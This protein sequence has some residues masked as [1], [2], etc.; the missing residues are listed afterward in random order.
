MKYQRFGKSDMDVSVI[1]LGNWASG[2][3]RWGKVEE[4]DAIRA[5]RLAVDLG[6]NFFDTAK[7]YGWG[8]SEQV[9]G[10]SLEGIRHKVHVTTKMGR[11]PR[12]DGQPGIGP[13]DLSP[14]TYQKSIEESLRNLR[15]EY[16]DL[17]MAHAY[18]GITPLDEMAGGFEHLREQGKIRW[19]GVSSFS[20]KWLPV[21]AKYPGFVGY[22]GLL[23]LVEKDAMDE[24]IPFCVS[25]SIGFMGFTPLGMGLLTGKYDTLPEFETDDVRTGRYYFT[26]EGFAAAQPG[27]AVMR[28]I[29][30]E[31]G[32]TPA[33]IATAWVLHAGA[34]VAV[35]GYKSEAQVKD[36]TSAGSLEL[37]EA[38]VKELDLVFQGTSSNEDRYGVNS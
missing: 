34:T 23:N 1:C 29:A 11:R 31:R 4:S 15:T 7:A 22:Q 21:L 25:S 37:D 35:V 24:I 26:P 30:N 36:N 13:V 32:V 5:T 20:P 38:E 16:V 9:L 14:Q 2:E 17:F 18:D 27:I 10:K 19:W 12:L 28:R 33:Q 6:V 3:K 8:L